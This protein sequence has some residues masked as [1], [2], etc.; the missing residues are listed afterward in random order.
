MKKL[1]KKL[2]RLGAALALFAAL[3]LALVFGG[4]SNGSDNSAALLALLDG[5]PGGGD[6]Q[7]TPTPEN[8][9][10]VNGKAVGQRYIGVTDKNSKVFVSNRTVTIKNL[11]V[12]D[13]EVTQS[14]YQDVMGTNPSEFNGTGNYV[15]AKGEK[16]ADRP[17]ENVSWYDTIVYCNKKSIKENLTPCYKMQKK[18]GAELST[19]PDDWGDVP[20]WTDDQSRWEAVT[21]DFDA[22][23]FRLPTEAEWEYLAIGGDVDCYDMYVGTD[24][25]AQLE[26][27]AWYKDNSGDKTHEVRKKTKNSANLFDLNGNVREWVWDFYADQLSSTTPYS[28]P[29]I[30]EAASGNRRIYRGGDWRNEYTFCRITGRYAEFPWNKSSSTG[31]R[32]VRT[33][34]E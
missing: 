25:A 23:G 3:G 31:F 27:Y 17:V 1:G 10:K 15:A 6:Q 33:R 16:Q 32:L 20:G 7:V 2:P 13:S 9:V 29:S 22:N 24:D 12:S 14:Q 5:G 4:C 34:T 11:W 18:D 26:K 30:S 8:F 21:C 28:G 19:N